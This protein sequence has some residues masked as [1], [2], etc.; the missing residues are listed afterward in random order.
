MALSTDLL[1]Q[2]R[3]TLRSRLREIEAEQR[4]AEAV[5]KDVRQR[6]LRVKRE[7]EAITTLIDLASTDSDSE[8]ESE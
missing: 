5:L 7:I 1:E 3:E 4:K 2:E 6:E 8:S